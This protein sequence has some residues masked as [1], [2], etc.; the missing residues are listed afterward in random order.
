VYVSVDEPFNSFDRLVLNHL[1]VP[2]INNKLC[3]GSLKLVY[4][5]NQIY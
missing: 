4:V 1:S 2:G 3:L 5:I